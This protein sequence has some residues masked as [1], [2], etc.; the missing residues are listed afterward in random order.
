MFSLNGRKLLSKAVEN[1]P[2]KVLSV[3]LALVLFVFHR[4]NMLQSRV[5]SVPLNV[6]VSSR[7]VPASSYPRMVRLSLR[8]DAESIYTIA[9]NDVEAYL[10]LTRHTETGSYRAPVQLRKKGTALEMDTLEI[11]V[12]P[13]EVSLELDQ[14]IS[15]LVPLTPDFQ[16]YLKEGFEL[17]SYTLNPN[18]VVVDGPLRAMSGLSELFTETI[19]LGGRTENFTVPVRILNRDPL[20]VIRG[21]GSTEFRGFVQGLIMIRTLEE[22]P[23]VLEGLNGRFTAELDPEFGSIRAEGNQNELEGYEPAAFRLTLDG[24]A[25]QREGSYT[26]PVTAAVPPNVTLIRAEPETVTV[27]VDDNPPP[28]ETP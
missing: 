18:Q 7:L 13:M 9:E 5:F 6:E 20:L 23:I 28:G 8:G 15:K 22:I 4:I 10:D 24:G 25:I 21:E 12:E 16:G 19:D 2:A 11:A 1:W 3:A 27:R 17:V 14:K 26:L